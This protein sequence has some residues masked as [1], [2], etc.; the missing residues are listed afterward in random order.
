MKILTIVWSIGVGGTE[1]AA[2][3]YA[4]GYRQYGHDSKVLVLGEGNE[5]LA[6]LQEAGVDTCFSQEDKRGA[7]IVFAEFNK[8]APDIIHLHNFTN[9][10]LPYLDKIKTESTKVVETNH[11]SRPNFTEEYKAVSLSMQ[12]S[13]WGY[14]KYTRWMKNAAYIPQVAI[15]PNIINAKKFTTPSRESISSFL[16]LHGIPANAFVAGRLGQAHPSKWDSRIFEVAERTTKPENNIYYLFVGM[17]AAMIKELEGKTDFIKSRIKLIPSI[18]GDENLSL[19]Y[20]SL[21]C[22]AHISKIGESFGY[23]LTEAMMC[24]VPVI[25]MLTPFHDNAQFEVVEHNYGGIC[26]TDTKGFVS[27]V[28]Q[29]YNSPADCEQFKKN[30]SEHWVENRFAA[31]AVTPKQIEYFLQLRAGKQITARDVSAVIKNC[32]AM[33]GASKHIMYFF[34]KLY[35]CRTSFL[36]LRCIKRTLK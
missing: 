15:V 34:L 7:E 3:N 4:I 23:V 10:F 28:M 27:A 19:Y 36:F 32:F 6:E 22:F 31:A 30:L 13:Q 2:V 18:D 12:L 11:F 24:S 26:V 25:T 33:Y 8:W 1:R 9:A 35:N 5:R 21:N 16:Q 20:R 17:P 14:W 29:L